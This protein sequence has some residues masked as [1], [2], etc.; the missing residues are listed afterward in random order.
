MS[1]DKYSL[2]N[3][4]NRIN[5][6]TCAKIVSTFVLDIWK[7]D[8]SHSL[9]SPVRSFTRYIA[10]HVVGFLRRVMLGVSCK[11][12]SNCCSLTPV[13]NNISSAVIDLLVSKSNSGLSLLIVF[14]SILQMSLIWEAVNLCVVLHK[15]ST[16]SQS[17]SSRWWWHIRAFS[18]R[19]NLCSHNICILIDSGIRWRVRLEQDRKMQWAVVFDTLKYSGLVIESW[20]FS[21]G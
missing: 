6:S 7:R 8:D 12:A 21:K 16:A 14:I 5:S 4:F 15:S 18:G 3:N 9:V 17:F 2:L 10:N 20:T 13:Q 1:G 19:Y 11:I